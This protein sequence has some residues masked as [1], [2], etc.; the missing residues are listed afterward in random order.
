MVISLFLRDKKKFKLMKQFLKNQLCVIIRQEFHN[1]SSEKNDFFSSKEMA[2]NATHIFK[3][4][5]KY[6]VFKQET[7][8]LITSANSIHFFFQIIKIRMELEKILQF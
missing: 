6:T 3:A 2:I 5:I 8:S 7:F 1:K 4:D